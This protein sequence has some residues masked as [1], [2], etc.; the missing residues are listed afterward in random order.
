MVPKYNKNLQHIYYLSYSK[1]CSVNNYILNREKKLKYIKF[2]K[3]LNLI[4]KTER[5]CIIMKKNIKDTF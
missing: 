5:Y 3:V 1:D 2:Q 4:L